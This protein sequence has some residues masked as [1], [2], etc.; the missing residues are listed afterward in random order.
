MESSRR[1]VRDEAVN[2]SQVAR[3]DE[4]FHYR[5]YSPFS[6]LLN[7]IVCA[8]VLRN[9]CFGVSVYMQRTMQPY[10]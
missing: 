10:I 8:L 5:H 7:G 6:A 1:L 4:R 2:G 3:R 9:S